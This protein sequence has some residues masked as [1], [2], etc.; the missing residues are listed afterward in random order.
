MR[1]RLLASLPLLA[2]AVVTLLASSS[3]AP[4]PGFSPR[5]IPLYGQVLL[6]SAS[7]NPLQDP[8]PRESIFGGTLGIH[9]T[10]WKGDQQA[11]A[12]DMA[13]T[14]LAAGRL[15]WI[16]FKAPPPPGSSTP[17]TWSEMATGAGDQWAADLAKRL[18]LLKGPVWVA[19]HH[20]PENDVGN[21]QD[22]TR[23]QQRLSPFFRSKPNIAYT[24]ILMGYHQFLAPADPRLSM[25][26]LW[27]GSRFVDVTGFDPYNTYGTRNPSGTINAT[28]TELKDYY[29]KIAS[30]SDSVGGAPWAVSET[31]LTDPAAERD[32]DW[33]TRGYDD[34]RTMG[35][36]ALTYWDNQVASK[37]DSTFRL[38]SVAKQKAFAAIL[39]RSD[40]IN[41]PAPSSRPS[42]DR[43]E[44]SPPIPQ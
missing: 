30:W 19:I 20:E 26:A 39:A 34:M 44:P 3:A 7:G 9:R 22:W 23:M 13:A 16:S 6:G 14:D 8:R 41:D 5:G 29:A 11:K 2:I 15:P 40:R 25:T 17:Y 27:P 24:V 12:V 10:Y 42:L 36:I 1:W 38:D 4:E 33:L 31:G 43:P 37:P 18:S 32:V 21:L 35:G 28:F